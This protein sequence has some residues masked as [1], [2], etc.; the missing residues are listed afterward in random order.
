MKQYKLLEI[1]TQ[2]DQYLRQ[3]YR[4]HTDIDKLS[5]DELF[6]MFGEDSFAESDFLHRYLCELEIESKLIFCNNRNLQD[7]WVKNNKKLSYFDILL[8]QIKEFSPDVILIS[9]MN[10]F[11]R[12]ETIIIKDCLPECG[13]LVGFHFSDI[14]DKFM[15]NVSLYDQ[16][17][18]GCAY[19]VNIM[20]NK[21]IPAYLLRHAFE[22]SILDKLS[23]SEKENK[24]C[25]SGSVYLNKNI[26]SNRL[27]MFNK[28]IESNIPFDFYG[29]IQGNIQSDDST[30]ENGLSVSVKEKQQKYLNIIKKIEKYRKPGLFGIGYYDIL[31]QY[32]IGIN[33]HTP[34]I[35]NGAGNIRMFETTGIGSCLLTDYKSENAELFDVEN[36]IVVYKS[37]EDM[38][39][40]AKW[41]LENPKKAKEIALAGQRKTLTKYTYKNKAEQLNEYIQELLK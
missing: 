21:G 19:F 6:S 28:L 11:T 8:L 35:G 7:K 4:T 32:N 9:N 39:E 16:I 18:T 24:I 27:D 33:M 34:I 30:A 10:Y 40:K 2:Y 25:F 36:E 3:F 12:E 23:K 17:Y 20:R 15:Q 14:R 29:D 22:P 31:N 13:K 41:L 37:I 26:H 38:V 5:Y 1:E